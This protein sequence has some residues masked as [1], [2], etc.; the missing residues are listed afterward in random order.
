MAYD[1]FIERSDPGSFIREATLSDSSISDALLEDGL[2]WN[3]LG[4][5]ADPETVTL[6]HEFGTGRR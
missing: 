1:T 5:V 6:W 4:E 2:E 3:F